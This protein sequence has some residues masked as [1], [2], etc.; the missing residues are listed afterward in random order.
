MEVDHRG[1]RPDAPMIVTFADIG[2]D[3]LPRV[4]GKAANLGTLTRAGILVPTGFCI[5]TRAFDRFVATLPN[6]DIHFKALEALD[7]TSLDSARAAAESIRSAL[8]ALVI[9]DEVARAVVSA[10]GALGPEH[11][12]AVRSSATAEDLPGASFAGQQDT[13]LNVRGEGPL[14]E[15]VR[16]CWISL[17]T[18]RAVIYRARGHFGHRSVRLAVI[19]Q[20]LIDPDVSGILFTAD[21]VTGHRHI[22]SIDAG[23]G[24]GE[25]LVSGVISADLYRVDKRSGEV[26]LARPGDKPF[27]IRSV[28]GGG[29]RREALPESERHS[30]AL[31]DQQVRALANLGARIEG[32]YG[33]APQDIEWC[34]AE[35]TIYVLQARPITSLFPIPETPGADGGVRVF[36]SFGHLQMMLDPMPRLAQQVWQLFLPAAKKHAPTLRSPPS[37]SPVMLPA[38]SRLYID[39]TGVMRIRWLRG[40]LLGLLSRAYAALAQSMAALVDRREFQEGRGASGSVFRLALRALGPVATRVPVAVLFEDPTAGA[41]VFQRALDEI[42]RETLERVKATTTLADRIRQCAVEL[43]ATFWRIRR[44]LPRMIAG[45]ISFGMLKRLARGRWADGLRDDV[46]V[47]MRGL[48]G[49][50][51]TEMDLA[52]GDLTDLLRPHPEAAALLRTHPW[53]EARR[54]LPSVNG[55]REFMLALDGFLARYGNRGASEIDVSRPRWRD[56]PSLLLSVMTGGL[57]AGDA[58][59]HRRHY[60]VQVDAAEA[61]AARLVS[62]AGSGIWG[63]FRR[64]WVRRFVRVARSGMGLREHPKFIIVQVLAVVRSEV[65]SA[66]E[67]LAQRGQLAEARDVWHLGFD[68][69]ATALDDPTLDV[70]DRVAVRAAD[71]RR[72]QDRKPPI[73][74]SS[75][76]EIP[77]PGADRADLPSNALAGTAASAGVVEGI[78]RVIRDPSREVLQAGEILVAPFTDP[79]W[80]PLFVHAVGLVTEV[81]GVMTHGAV[82][83]REY[84]IPAVVSVASAVDRIKTGQRIRVDG[85]RGF[86]QFLEEQ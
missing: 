42:P 18:D 66:G 47:L 20:R 60:R 45:F 80:T 75:E 56:D 74:M 39:V 6:A 79:G 24:L 3:D 37:L 27:A 81:G 72:D 57:A 13:F 22:A 1:E 50:V 14:L 30:R 10:W 36:L 26:L 62:A 31:D 34:L 73:A 48:P 11:A 9:P 51:T 43:N 53:T 29:T 12:L 15:A 86:V 2:A 69:L 65:L 16:R 8:D 67:I 17:F 41:A 54:S 82:V 83:A 32:L 7:G 68:E 38:G 23:F 5:T 28:K 19:V 70:R 40:A 46:D 59:A 77:T 61:A 64:H 55:G 44:Y 78:A 35:G 25:A 71:V 63:R 76:G 4:G 21:P 84:G 52:V 85:T 58:G 49:N 33:G